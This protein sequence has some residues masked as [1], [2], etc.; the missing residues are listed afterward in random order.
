[1][2]VAILVPC[3]NEEITIGQVVADFRAVLPEADIYVFDNNSSDRTAEEARLA[4]AIVLSER[5]QGKGFVVQSMFSRVDADVYVMVDGDGTYPP[6]AVLQLVAPVILGEAD[7][8]VGS[9][10]HTESQS[11]FKYANRWGNRLVLALLNAIFRVQLTDILSG[12][13]AFSR[14]FVKSL[15]LFGGGFEIETE[16]TIKAVARSYRII[17]IPIDLVHRPEGSHSKIRFLRD[18]AIILNTILALFRDYKPLTF[19]GGVGL[20]LIVIGLVPGTIVIVEFINT[21]LVPR[22][23]S[24]VLAVGFVLCGLLSFTVGLILHSIA[25]RSQEFEYQLQVLSHELRSAREAAGVEGTSS[26]QED[27]G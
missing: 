6:D 8:V 24:A 19:F 14:N 15:P 11:Q 3:Y 20:L 23:P 9:R 25:R 7:M 27:R 10:L 22:L 21:G 18:G 1:M 26:R 13:R 4:G 12:Y 17:E 5:R 2:R 16:L